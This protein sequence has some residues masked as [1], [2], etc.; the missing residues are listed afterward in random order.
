M[1]KKLNNWL[2]EQRNTRAYNKAEN[3]IFKD[4]SID[5]G[6]TIDRCVSGFMCVCPA[7]KISS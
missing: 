3:T 2:L 4:N 6:S 7:N 5:L 1:N